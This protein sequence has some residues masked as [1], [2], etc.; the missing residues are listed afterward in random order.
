[1]LRL[2]T[3]IDNLYKDGQG[4]TDEQAKTLTEILRQNLELADKQICRC[5]LGILGLWLLAIGIARSVFSEVSFLSV[6]IKDLHSILLVLP[7]A[8]GALYYGLLAAVCEEAI[9]QFVVREL[10]RHHYKK[11]YDN[12]LE[13][14][15]LLPGFLSA[16][17][18][19]RE[20]IE[21]CLKKIYWWWGIALVSIA[22]IIPLVCITHVAYLTIACGT[23]PFWLRIVGVSLS[24]LV[25]LRGVV[26]FVT[27][28]II[29]Y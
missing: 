11:L 13:D 19:T 2:S 5:F 26:L 7:L 12:D 18:M 23:G 15:M 14:L 10:I 3:A 16:E 4:F 25:S 21:G 1:M 27:H 8:I 17:I 24:A 29:A 22:V 6:S 20:H 9:Y 28:T